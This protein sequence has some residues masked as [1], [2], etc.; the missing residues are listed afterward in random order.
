MTELEKLKELQAKISRLSHVRKSDTAYW[1]ARQ[2]SADLSALSVADRNINLDI[3]I[4]DKYS[5]KSTDKN[6]EYIINEFKEES[7]FDIR[8]LIIGLENRPDTTI[9]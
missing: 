3:Q 7:M 1:E 9:V 2:I 6:K 5:F 4:L 8:N